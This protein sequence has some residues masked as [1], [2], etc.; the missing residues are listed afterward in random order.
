MEALKVAVALLVWPLAAFPQA[1]IEYGAGV[2]RAAVSGAGIGSVGKS[3][4]GLLDKSAKRMEPVQ[5]Q[6]GK[7]AT[8]TA[9]GS[10]PVQ[11]VAVKVQPPSSHIPAIDP[12]AIPVGLEREELFRQFGKPSMRITQQQGGEVVE[13]CWYKAA[14]FDPVVV[15]LRNGKV[16]S[17]GT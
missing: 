1:I 5:T 4:G 14:G 11:A 2:G 10:E 16:A 7:V 9:K 6:K 3:T 12:A 17:V 8:R 13:R 15:T